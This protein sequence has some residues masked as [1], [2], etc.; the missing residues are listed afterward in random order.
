MKVFQK[1]SLCAAALVLGSAALVGVREHKENIVA[2]AQEATAIEVD[3]TQVQVRSP[4]DA[5]DYRLLVFF[6]S[7][8]T[9]EGATNNQALA[10]S[11]DLNTRSK[12]HFEFRDGS[13]YTLG[14]LM[15]N[16]NYYQMLWGDNAFATDPLSS[17][18]CGNVTN[19]VRIY[20]EKG[21]EFPKQGSTTEKFVLSSDFACMNLNG[22]DSNNVMTFNQP[23]QSLSKLTKV[24]D[25]SLIGVG[26]PGKAGDTEAPKQ[27]FIDAINS[28]WTEVGYN[29]AIGQ[30]MNVAC[31]FMSKISFDGN[32]IAS[33][34]EDNRYGLDAGES[35]SI[36]LNRWARAGQ[37]LSFMVN[38]V[39][40][41][42]TFSKVVIPQGTMLPSSQNP[43]GS[44]SYEVKYLSIDNTY[45]F[46]NNGD[47][48]WNY[49][50]DEV[51][52]DNVAN[53]SATA[54][55][56]AKFADGNIWAMFKLPGV[57]KNNADIVAV[58][59]FIGRKYLEAS[60]VGSKVTVNG[61]PLSTV[62]HG[63]H[64]V[65]G[66][67]DQDFALH[68]NVP[69]ATVDTWH[70]FVIPEGTAFLSAAAFDLG[71]AESKVSWIV[72][73]KPMIAINNNGVWT[74]ATVQNVQLG[75]SFMYEGNQSKEGGT[76][77]GI[78]YAFYVPGLAP[79]V[80][81]GEAN[82]ITV[83]ATELGNQ[84]M[85]ITKPVDYIVID[86]APIPNEYN[87]SATINWWGRG[88]NFFGLTSVYPETKMEI[89]WMDVK[90]GMIIPTAKTL[91]GQ[92]AK[93]LRV[94]T[95]RTYFYNYSSGDRTQQIMSTSEFEQFF[96]DYTSTE[97]A[98][99]SESAAFTADTFKNIWKYTKRIYN[100]MYEEQR[101]AL[102]TSDSQAMQ[103]YDY[104]VA[105]YNL[106]NFINRAQA[107]N[108][109][110][111]PVSTNYALMNIAIVG[112]VALGGVLLI[113]ANR[114][115]EER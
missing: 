40:D 93:V 94:E 66:Y 46:T 60:Q 59:S 33:Y 38:G 107:A 88:G 109:T 21:C 114:R 95:T 68:L 29:Y 41:T 44:Y 47:G 91:A 112:V 27:F 61:Q 19:I 37:H 25:V 84:L 30:A 48:S 69:I 85:N 5:T 17:D 73:S 78:D 32:T 97:C 2:K 55:N 77:N 70:T 81:S 22:I 45:V 7:P 39:T 52:G 115:R 105:K 63:N 20:F 92:E 42:R 8:W 28:D 101:A 18:L 26:D 76:N 35:A 11:A 9:N 71:A 58:E 10:L 51:Y 64:G 3:I 75:G 36:V 111:Q 102:I 4:K 74:M 99:A 79:E 57:N 100:A 82:A 56:W 34:S 110:L 31:G 106:E 15:V 16:N 62:M 87:N 53:V 90:A 23:G 49:V 98:F 89:S 54:F 103:R 113:K 86:N 65:G 72:L 14:E 50:L 12:I 43:N 96:L 83:R 1:I 6:A 80:R 67:S 108:N 104:L 24:S 13:S